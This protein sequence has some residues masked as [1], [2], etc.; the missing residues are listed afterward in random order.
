M[1]VEISSVASAFAGR[2]SHC[3]MAILGLPQDPFAGLV[4]CTYHHWF[5]FAYK[6]RCYYQLSV[7]GGQLQ[8]FLQFKF[9]SHNLPVVNGRFAGARQVA[10]TNNCKACMRCHSLVGLLLQVS[11][12]KCIICVMF[13]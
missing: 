12:T 1:V 2:F 7:C 8:R 6:R 13:F 9:G 4:S 10:K 11:C 5:N 3:P